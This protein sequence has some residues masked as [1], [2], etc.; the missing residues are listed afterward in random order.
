MK[1]IMIVAILFPICCLSQSSKWES[2]GQFSGSA[3]VF[4]EDITA[5]NLFIGGE[6]LFYNGDTLRGI[7]IWNGSTMSNMGCGFDWD[8][9]N[10]NTWGS[11]FR[12]THIAKY[13]NNIYIG[14]L[15]K[16]ANGKTVNGLTYWDGNDFQQIG[17]GLKGNGGTAGVCWSMTILNNELYVGGAFDSIV[18]IPVNSLGKYDGQA[19]SAVH[20]LPRFLPDDI[21]FV[22]AIAEYSGE[23]YVGGNFHDLDTINDLVKWNGSAWEGVSGFEEPSGI[24]DMIVYKGQ[25][26]VSGDFH[27]IGD[28]VQNGYDI[29]RYDGVHWHDVGGGVLGGQIDKMVT[30]GNYLYVAGGFNYAGSI[31]CKNLAR[32]DG[33]QWCS[34]NSVFDNK[35]NAVGFY[36]D[37]MYIGGGFWSIDGDTSLAK[38]VRYIGVDSLFPCS[39]PTGINEMSPDNFQFNV[40]PNP[41][42]DQFSIRFANNISGNVRIALSNVIGETLFSQSLSSIIAKQQIQFD[43][44]DFAAGIYLITIKTENET[45]ALKIVKQ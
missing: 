6:Y 44:S 16:K 1:Q 31:S 29:V 3:S 33:N 20:N 15:F 19:W 8:C 23:L 45:H 14:G 7:G 26:Y 9:V 41:T 4:F 27:F 17:T 2:I 18:G 37:T 24:I 30:D 28:G 11:V 10:P 42:F 40:F 43:V 12:P 35:V 22:N 21:N 36:R 13:D 32:W 34:Y 25:L 38:V 39:Q 5:D